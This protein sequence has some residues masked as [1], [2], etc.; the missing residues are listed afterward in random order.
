MRHWRQARAAARNLFGTGA[1]V[2][3]LGNVLTTR[4]ELPAGGAVV[5]SGAVALLV[6]GVVDM[7]GLYRYSAAVDAAVDDLDR[8]LTAW[9]ETGAESDP[10]RR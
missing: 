5:S 1:L 7:V 6:G 3:L 10:N 2:A 4:W 8:R 9:G